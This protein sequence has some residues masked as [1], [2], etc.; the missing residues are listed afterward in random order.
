M[1]SAKSLNVSG[2]SKWCR[3][4]RLVLLNPDAFPCQFVVA[5]I[6]NNRSINIT[7]GLF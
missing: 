3:H 6:I 7:K 4:T 5:L 2:N 1:D